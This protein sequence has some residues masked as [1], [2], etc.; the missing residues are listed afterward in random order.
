MKASLGSEQWCTFLGNVNRDE[1]LAVYS[2][3]EIACFPSW[4]EAYGIVCLEAMACPMLTIG[5]NKGGMKEII[6]DGV[7]GFLIEPK[8]PIELAYKIK[9]V[10]SLPKEKKDVIRHNAIEKVLKSF[11]IEN[12]GEQMLEYYRLIQT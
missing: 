5:S 7:D 10:H 2:R 1:L 11:D 9:E 4:W 12:I 8:N 6:T 3:N